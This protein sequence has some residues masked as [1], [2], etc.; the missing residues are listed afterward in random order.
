LIATHN[1]DLAHRMDRV[2]ELK[3]GLLIDG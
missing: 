2:I 3:D 1:L